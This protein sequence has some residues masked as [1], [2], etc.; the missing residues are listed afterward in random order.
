MNLEIT[1]LKECSESQSAFVWFNASKGSATVTRM[2]ALGGDNA[3]SVCGNNDLTE[4]AIIAAIENSLGESGM[5]QLE[6][7]LDLKD[8][9]QASTARPLPWMEGRITR[10]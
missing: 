8:A 3:A 7:E 4:Q 2:L 1:K 10:Y 6:Q 9:M 5:L